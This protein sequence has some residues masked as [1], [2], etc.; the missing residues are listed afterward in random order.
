VRTRDAL[1]LA[2]VPGPFAVQGIE[3]I[4]EVMAARL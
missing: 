2:D 3:L 1:P 4:F